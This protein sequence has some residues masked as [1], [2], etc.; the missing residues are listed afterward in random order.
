MQFIKFISNTLKIFVTNLL[1]CFTSKNPKKIL[2]N[3][4]IKND[5]K[6]IAKNPKH[7][8]RPLK[9]CLSGNVM[10]FIKFISNI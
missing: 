3:S 1:H 9:Q 5:L 2:C 4:F 10:Q 7:Y 8:F 6:L